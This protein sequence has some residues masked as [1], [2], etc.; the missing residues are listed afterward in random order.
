VSI[1]VSVDGVV[2][3]RSAEK[4]FAFRGEVKEKA[5][6]LA[7]Y[8]LHLE[9]KMV[10]RLTFTPFPISIPLSDTHILYPYPI[11]L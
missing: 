3:E 4:P 6:G 8:I 11:P 7:V 9:N 1:N 5:G 2:I 10:S